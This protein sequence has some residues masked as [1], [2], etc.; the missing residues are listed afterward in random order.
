MGDYEES[1][2]FAGVM[3]RREPIRSEQSEYLVAA[4]ILRPP[5][6]QKVAGNRR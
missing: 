2:E 5:A 3:F 6:Q 1:S 4:E